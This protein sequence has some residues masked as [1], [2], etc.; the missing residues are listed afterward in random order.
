MGTDVRVIVTEHA[1]GRAVDRTPLEPGYVAAEIAREVADALRAGRLACR[2]PR[3]L[4]PR[5][6]RPRLAHSA[7]IVWNLSHSRA[8]VLRPERRNG[9]RTWVVLTCLADGEIA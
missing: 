5:G 9:V 3:F 4:V 2:K 6:R 1:A 7:R 8:Y